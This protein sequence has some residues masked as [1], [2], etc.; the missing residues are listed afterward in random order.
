[1]KICV[2]TGTRAEYGLLQNLMK[3]VKLDKKLKL[4]LI[5]TGM[6]LSK[7]FGN[8]YKDI[9]KD[10]FKINK[11]VDIKV[12]KDT[13]KDIINSTSLGMKYFIKAYNELKPDIIMIVGDRYEAFAAATA[14]CF[15]KIPIAHIHGGE[16]T[17]GLIDEALR[18]SITKMSHL[19]FVA[20][21][22]YKK[23][24]IQLG[25]N[26]KNVFNVGGLGADNLKNFRPMKLKSLEKEL[27]IKFR[28][29][30]LIINYH[31][32]TLN[33]FSAKKEF[34][35]IITCLKNL[36]NH[37][38]FFSMPNAD[39]GNNVIFN[40][41]KRFV[42][43]NKYSYFF[44]SAGKNK[45]LSCLYYVD[46]MI[47]NSSSGLLEMPSLKKGTIN[48]GDRQKGRLMATSVIKIKP[49]KK[50]IN[51]AL[52]KLYSNKF[53]NQLKNTKNPYGTGNA[54]SKIIKILKKTKLKNI[55]FKKFYSI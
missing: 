49:K 18:H 40:T 38:L 21:K 13:S 20:A 31:P 43:S 5:V 23:K 47:G 35:E 8:T 41:I 12:K 36:K 24:V 30:N 28:K 55:L 1:M 26:P 2:I 45:F 46:G 39:Q 22:N 48:I 54:S 33:Y 29:R 4:Q 10:G 52:K 3:K 32:V 27:K 19:H 9:L 42:K 15:A 44:V 53:Q 37:S 11:K 50:E 17:E 51:K 16:S 6:H 7:K 25:E 34:S 14:A